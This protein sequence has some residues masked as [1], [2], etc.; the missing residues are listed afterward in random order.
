MKKISLDYIPVRSKEIL[1][2]I[3]PEGTVSLM[4]VKEVDSFF[5]LDALA[6]ETWNLIDDKLNLQQMAA[7][8]IEKHHPP[9]EQ[10]YDDLR[11]LIFNLKKEKI[12]N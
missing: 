12:L 4:N 2:R 7:K 9:V 8:I 6:A 11:D 5:I 3:N 10:F 1:S